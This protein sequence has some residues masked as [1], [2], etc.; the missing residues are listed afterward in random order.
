MY[1]YRKG[2]NLIVPARVSIPK[3]SFIGDTKIELKPG[4]KAYKAWA[5]WVKLMPHYLKPWPKT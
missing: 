1:V 2:K 5:D 4:D 3:K